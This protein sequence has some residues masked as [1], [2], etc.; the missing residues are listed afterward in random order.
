AKPS[1]SIWRT[2]TAKAEL[3]MASNDYHF[4]T[5]WRVEGTIEEVYEIL[6]NAPD[7]A[8]WWPSVYLDVQVLEPGDEHGVGKTVSLHTRGWLPYTLRWQFQVMESRYPHGFTLEA[9]GDFV[10]RGIWKSQQDGP[11]VNITYSWKIRVNKPLLRYLS[12]LMKPIFAANHRWAMKKGE[13]SLR[14]ELARRHGQ[15]SENWA[16]ASAT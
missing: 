2:G 6:D 16:P 11:Y 13:E 3:N 4:I 5:H 12:F 7:L 10:G 15:R 9:Q 14:L 1:V 8:R